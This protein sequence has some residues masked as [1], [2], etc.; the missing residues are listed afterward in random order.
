M[1]FYM[2][3]A[4]GKNLV[5]TLTVL[6]CILFLTGCGSTVSKKVI[7]PSMPSV[8]SPSVNASDFKL[9][10]SRVKED[11]DQ[12]NKSILFS[13]KSPDYSAIDG[14]HIGLE[15]SIS[16]DDG[17]SNWNFGLGSTYIGIDWMF[18]D[19]IDLKSDGG[20]MTWNIDPSTRN[21][22]VLDGEVF[23][24]AE[25]QPSDD[26]I[27]TFCNIVRAKNVL[28]RLTG[29]GG[30]VSDETAPMT[31][32]SISQNKDVCTIYEGLQAGLKP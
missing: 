12:F 25:Y 2:H 24:V 14:T 28:F 26:E 6:V 18:H 15:A 5:G 11:K 22:Q 23:E 31:L 30:A 29:S 19:T 4:F 8:P 16:S 3:R 21:D 9:A 32:D 17:V 27:S 1:K 20:T 7:A 10:L 13:S